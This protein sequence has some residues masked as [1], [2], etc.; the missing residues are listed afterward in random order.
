MAAVPRD[1]AGQ[2]Q[3]GQLQHG[4]QID[5]DQQVDAICVRLQ[6]G[7]G[8]VDAGI[9]DQDVEWLVLRKLG[10]AGEVGHVD[11]VRDA[12]GARGER[13]QRLGAAR[14]GMDLQLLSAESLDGGRA[15]AG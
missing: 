14:E 6:D 12:S 2:H 1:H 15:D 5:V 8:T 13:L 11:R 9:V 3:P 10:D 7:A 4:A